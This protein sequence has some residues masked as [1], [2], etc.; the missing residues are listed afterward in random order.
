MMNTTGSVNTSAS[1]TWSGRPTCSPDNCAT[2]ISAS[3]PMKPPSR[4]GLALANMTNSSCMHSTPS[5]NSVSANTPP[6]R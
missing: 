3:R 6:P 2:A 1:N 5:T 4:T